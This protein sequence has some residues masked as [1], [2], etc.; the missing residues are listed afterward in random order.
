MHDDVATPGVLLPVVHFTPQSLVLAA[1]PLKLTAVVIAFFGLGWNGAG[2]QF[3]SHIAARRHL[4]CT[5][6]HKLRLRL[7]SMVCPANARY[8]RYGSGGIDSVR[9]HSLFSVHFSLIPATGI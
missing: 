1:L 3:V 2:I 6:P 7:A 8:R 4:A 9:L 5:E